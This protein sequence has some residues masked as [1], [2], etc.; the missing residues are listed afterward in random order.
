M[1]RLAAS[2]KRSTRNT[3]S[4]SAFD[5]R[6]NQSGVP[7][8]RSICGRA[9]VINR[10]TSEP[11]PC[12]ALKETTTAGVDIFGLQF[13]FGG[14]SDFR[15]SDSRWEFLGL[16]VASLPLFMQISPFRFRLFSCAL[17]LQESM[18]ASR[19][20]SLVWWIF[21]GSHRRQFWEE[22][23]MPHGRSSPQAPT[24]GPGRV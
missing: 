15:L 16:E 11:S 3:V 14:D 8:S 9:A 12:F 19:P 1:S 17:L 24:V 4:G 5:R 10:A 13:R 6:T 2:R 20:A 18:G 23:R 21:S 22:R 7:S